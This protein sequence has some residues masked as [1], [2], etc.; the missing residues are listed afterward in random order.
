MSRENIHRPTNNFMLL[1]C[2]FDNLAWFCSTNV[3]NTNTLIQE[4]IILLIL[5]LQTNLQSNNPKCGLLFQEEALLI[6][7]KNTVVERIA[8]KSPK[9]FSKID[10]GLRLK[11]LSSAQY[12][13]GL[14]WGQP[15]VILR[16]FYVFLR[17][18]DGSG[19]WQ[20]SYS[21]LAM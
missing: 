8:A 16:S 6:S 10:I 17:L 18:E 4:L 19:A 1:L 7:D 9:S 14:N 15:V 12:F 21:S 13:F 2:S 5:L 11:L 3:P 20:V